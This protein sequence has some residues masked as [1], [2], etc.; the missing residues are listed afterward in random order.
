MSRVLLRLT[1]RDALVRDAE[2]QPPDVEMCQAVDASRGEGSAVVAADG[3]GKPMLAEEAAELGLHARRAD[4][5]QPVAGEQVAAE[6]VDDGEGIAVAAVA[7][8]ELP[9]EV[10]GPDLIGSRGAEG[11][12]PG[13]LP[14]RALATGTN[15]PVAQEDVADR[16]AGR[17]GLVGI[18][19]EETLADFASAGGLK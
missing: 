4:V 7:H 19:P 2:L 10:D 1:W 3:I 17:P 11:S 13:V 16:A 15:A 5:E 12:G 18:P 6:V 14:M 8:P 9:L